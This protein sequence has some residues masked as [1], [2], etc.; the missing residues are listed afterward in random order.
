M[1][2]N[3]A[4]NLVD[5]RKVVDGPRV[6]TRW[7]RKCLCRMIYVCVKQLCLT[8]FACVCVGAFG[9]YGSYT[10]ISEEKSVCRSLE[11]VSKAGRGVFRNYFHLFEL[12]T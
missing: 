9:L 4:L 7:S 6:A 10:E 3:W 1:K 8:M 5:P 11:S 2:E 12:G